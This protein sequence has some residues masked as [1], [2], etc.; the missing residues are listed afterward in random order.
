MGKISITV[1]TEMFR[2]RIEKI[3]NNHGF[4]EIEA[5]R[6]TTLSIK[7][8]D[9]QYKNSELVILDLDIDS[10]MVDGIIQEI[11]RHSKIHDVPIIL[12]ASTPDLSIIKKMSLHGG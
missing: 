2:F 8:I 7:N 3:L 9:Y 10:E 4:Y 1:D 5:I 12:L 11:R 6:S